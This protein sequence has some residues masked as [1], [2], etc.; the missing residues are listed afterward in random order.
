MLL[1][2]QPKLSQISTVGVL[3]NLGRFALTDSVLVAESY[4]PVTINFQNLDKEL[5]SLLEF[6]RD[7]VDALVRYL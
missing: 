2:W 5:I 6:I 1:F 7:L 4:T 3:A